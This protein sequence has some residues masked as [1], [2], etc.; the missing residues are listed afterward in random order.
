M[1]RNN[2]GRMAENSN[3]KQVVAQGK[4]S[5]SPARPSSTTTMVLQCEHKAFI[6]RT[7][8]P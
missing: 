3:I 5:L 7:I 1:S 6:T 4:Y 8:S 2:I